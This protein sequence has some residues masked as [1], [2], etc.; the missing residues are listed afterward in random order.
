MVAGDYQD[1]GTNTVGH[2][3]SK[4]RMYPSNIYFHDTSPGSNLTS[5]YNDRRIKYNGHAKWEFQDGKP[6][7]IELDG[8][9][10]NPSVQT[11]ERLAKACNASQNSPIK[12]T[13]YDIPQIANWLATSQYKSQVPG[14]AG[15]CGFVWPGGA[16]SYSKNS[17]TK[18]FDGD[19]DAWLFPE[20]VQVYFKFPADFGKQK[21][22]R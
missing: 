6:I 15:G 21:V 14:P 8:N 5:E 12:I 17:S 1:W 13:G 10:W 3:G 7:P 11:A 2:C 16:K 19:V 18:S 9:Q 4:Y 22:A 20:N